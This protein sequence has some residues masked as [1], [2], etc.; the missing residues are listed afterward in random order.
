MAKKEDK[1]VYDDEFLEEE[2]P[3]VKTKS[4]KI[5]NIIS[6]CIFVPVMIILVIYFVYSLSVIR[7]NGV[8]SF[9][10]QSYVRVLSRSMTASGFKKGDVVFIE[11]VKISEIKEGDIIAFYQCAFT[12][13]NDDGNIE[14][15]TDF[16]SGQKSFIT[17]IYFHKVYKIEYDTLGNTWFHTYG[18]SNIKNTMADPENI[19]EYYQ[20]DS[21]P[22]R[23]DHVVGRYVKSPFAGVIKFMSSPS[24]LIVLVI[25]PSG[26]LLFSLLLNIIEIIDLMMREK[27]QK[28]A[29]A[30]GEVKERELEVTTIIEEHDDE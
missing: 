21:A 4:S 10:G 8:P 17:P 7:N 13:Q 14:N 2:K 12:Q 28:A 1:K 19:E 20:V 22:T 15:A 9:F 23:G 16:K 18:T 25:V 24:G 30:D 5:I 29:F 11:K 6:N 26:I 3:K 27:K